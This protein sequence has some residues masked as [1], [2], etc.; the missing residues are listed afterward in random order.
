MPEWW[1][2]APIVS[3]APQ[4]SPAAS[5]ENW[6]DSAPLVSAPPAEPA[7]WFE[8]RWDAAA[9]RR[10]GLVEALPAVGG[11]IGGV[12]GGIGGT[13]LGLGVG[14]APG[15]IGGAALGGAAGE[16]ARQN[17]RR[18]QGLDAP[19]S[20]SEAAVEMGR[21]GAIQGAAQAAGAAVGAGMTRAAPWLMQSAVK[22]TLATLKEYGITSPR[23]ATML[24]E[25]GVNVTT[26][27]LGRLQ[28]LLKGTNQ[29]I[30]DLV[31]NAPG[32]VPKER[33]AA[34]V[35][36]TAQQIARQAN[37]TRDLKAVGNA[38][39][40]FL[41]HPIYQGDLT[42]AEAQ[43]M[44]QGTYR[45]IGKQYG[46]LSAAEV[47]AQKAIAR[48]LKEEVAEAAPGVSALNKKESEVLAGMEAVGRRVAISGNRDPVGFAW[49]THNPTTFI[50]ALLDRQPVV[51]SMIANG[52]W[53]S[54]AAVTGLSPNLIRAAVLSLVSGE[55]EGEPRPR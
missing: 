14:G 42:V 51:K 10:A 7:G 15:A 44:K 40:E 2:A 28:A 43:A 45:Q 6:W 29:E 36:T 11:G 33:V 5:G 8:S 9:P 20:P 30:A 53:S 48:G 24:L 22:P 4:A 54:A 46:E 37:P 16:A 21:E 25:E 27:G 50:A 19:T 49:V 39:D 35:A 18:L 26:G 55:S 13:V 47:E 31:R 32:E 17:I 23:L 12:V 1:E 41:N 38:V 3:P 34:R 52:M